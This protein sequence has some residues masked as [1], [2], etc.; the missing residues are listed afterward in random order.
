MTNNDSGNIPRISIDVNIQP[1]P[2][3]RAD[4]VKRDYSARLGRLLSKYEHELAVA[5]NVDALSPTYQL[6]EVA[7][8]I[9]RVGQ[10]VRRHEQ[11]AIDRAAAAELA[12]R[13]EAW[14]NAV[15]T[16]TN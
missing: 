16:K 15:A 5:L 6:A 13:G 2:F 4:Q 14:V 7:G 9:S 3:A 8:Y 12:E 10:V 1:S 11:L